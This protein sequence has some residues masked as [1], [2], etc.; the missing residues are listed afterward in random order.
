[1]T[2]GTDG[3]D[4]DRTF[5]MSGLWGSNVAL[6]WTGRYGSDLPSAARPDRE[7]LWHRSVSLA[8]RYGIESRLQLMLTRPKQPGGRPA[9]WGERDPY[10]IR[11]PVGLKNVIAA[12]AEEA[13]LP[14]ATHSVIVMA[15]HVGVQLSAAGSGQ[16][17][18]DGFRPST[19]FVPRGR[20][21]PRRP[22]GQD[23]GPRAP[24]YNLRMPI[25]VRALVEAAAEEA[26]LPL[27]EYSVV[28]L[29]EAHGFTLVGY[30]EREQQLTLQ[31]S[32]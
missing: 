29:A 4:A 2:S 1:M 6:R 23:W 14:L 26:E 13:G 25:E 28:V 3:P 11:V 16:T 31:V 30:D 15:D 22:R 18:L 17:T 21:L 19:R 12:A 9:Y 10:T 27:A 24:G 5:Q 20:R 7:S 8:A 32:A